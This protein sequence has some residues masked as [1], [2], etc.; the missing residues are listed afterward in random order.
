MSGNRS[1]PDRRVI[2]STLG[3]TQITAW[4]SYLPAVIAPAAAVDTGG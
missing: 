4:G 3:L 1:M 2:V